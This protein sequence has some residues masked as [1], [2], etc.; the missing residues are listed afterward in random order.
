[1][2]NSNKVVQGLSSGHRFY[3]PTMLTNAPRALHTVFVCMCV[4]VCVCVCIFKEYEQLAYT[5]CIIVICQSLSVNA[6]YLAKGNCFESL[7]VYRFMTLQAII[8][9][10]CSYIYIYIYIYIYKAALEVLHHCTW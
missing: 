5:K 1:M 10:K 6:A 7:I 2:G 3:Y 8:Q 4:C 9:A